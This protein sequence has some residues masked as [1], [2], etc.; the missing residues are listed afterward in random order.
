MRDRS[1]KLNGV[2]FDNAGD[3][4]MEMAW[5]SR[6]HVFSSNYRGLSDG[7]YEVARH[8][9]TT[10]GDGRLYWRRG[11]HDVWMAMKDNDEVIV[12][13]ALRPWIYP[14]VDMDQQ[15]DYLK[16]IVDDDPSDL[17]VLNQVK[18][19]SDG[20]LH[21]G[22]A[23]LNDPYAFS[24][25]KF[26]PYGLNYIGPEVLKR[27]L[28][29]LDKIGLGA[30]IH[31]LGDAAVRESLDA[32]AEVR[33]A[34]STRL[35]GMTHLELVARADLDRFQALDVDADFQAGA[36]YLEDTSWAANY[37][38]DR[39]YDMIPMREIFETGANVTFS[40]DWTVHD[41]NPLIGISNSLKLREGKGL[42][43]A[44]SAV[45]A[46]TINGARALGLDHI[47]GSLEVGKSADMVVLD[48][49]IL[50]SSWRQIRKTKVLMTI[51]RGER[52]YQRH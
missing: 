40:S 46:S 42:P 39:A 29:E 32:I 3:V 27:W 4:V 13:T 52:V 47:T 10:A 44:L 2:L 18:L 8:G 31:A 19:Y 6:D 36:D 49:D 7:M 45:K 34:G 21:F 16:T 1:G 15:L 48:R 5:N 14:D 35:Y 28:H 12:R 30:H 37:I 26:L 33:K 22:T 50:N 20:V 24:W 41:L 11:W 9:I 17:L 25:Q 51:L 23:K 43:D 38:D